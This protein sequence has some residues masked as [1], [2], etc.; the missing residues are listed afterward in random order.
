MS[1]DTY[2]SHIPRQDFSAVGLDSDVALLMAGDLH[3][4]SPD[5]YQNAGI[6]AGLIAEATIKVAHSSE[7][8]KADWEQVNNYIWNS[9]V[10]P[11]PDDS[12]AKTHLKQFCHLL[13]DVA[14]ADHAYIDLPEGGFSSYHTWKFKPRTIG[15]YVERKLE[16]DELDSEAEGLIRGLRESSLDLPTEQFKA[17]GER[18][19]SISGRIKELDPR[20]QDRWAWRDYDGPSLNNGYSRL[21]WDSLD[22]TARMVTSQAKFREALSDVIALNEHGPDI[23]QR[24]GAKG[25]NLLRLKA[26]IDG[27]KQAGVEVADFME[28]P[29]FMILPTDF[30]ESHRSGGKIIDGIRGIK[31]WIGV[32]DPSAAYIIR[33]SAVNSEDGEHM[34]AGIYDSV[35]LSA[36]A[37]LT[38][39]Y[40]AVKQVYGSVNSPQAI[41][42]RESIGVTDEQMAVVV[43]QVPDSNLY[44]TS[45]LTINTVMPHVPQLAHYELEVGVHPLVRTGEPDEYIR[46]FLP[47]DRMGMAYELG[48]RNHQHTPVAPRFHVPPD[49]RLHSTNDSWL[50]AQASLIAEKALGRPIQ[51]EALIPND[52]GDTIH[53]VQARPLPSEWLVA[54]EFVGFPE[55]EEAWYEGSGV[56]VYNGVEVTTKTGISEISLYLDGHDGIIM[57]TW[58]NSFAKSTLG[59]AIEFG[60][61]SL[62]EEDRRRVV[63]LIEGHPELSSASGYG[64]LETMFAEL[65]VGLVFADGEGGWSRKFV[66]G[67]KAR[68]YSNGYKAKLYSSEDDPAFKEDAERWERMYGEH[69]FNDE[70]ELEKEG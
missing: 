70:D 33:S 3:P 36:N 13:G 16:H 10:D 60:L 56:G 7:L 27:L 46:R 19:Q 44:E 42:Y 57:P 11:Q 65:G 18:L 8:S 31:Q 23:Q 30:Y 53:I 66:D 22:S 28:V 9:L 68:L 49:T 41:A 69:Q 1:F 55:G 12:E 34:G 38:Q 20:D 6:W 63:C 62:S 21:G 43:Q 4:S 64:H 59:R 67:Q 47:L 61:T 25:A 5:R 51:L 48:E 37:N 52:P 14:L 39:I 17:V 45:T 40:K 54:H 26:V 50:A 24:V 35:L 32:T 15:Q 58:D 2:E 29:P